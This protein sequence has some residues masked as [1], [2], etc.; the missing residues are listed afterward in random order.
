MIY[1]HF[2]F[3]S[4]IYIYVP[5]QTLFAGLK[6]LLE[7]EEDDIEEAFIQTFRVCYTDV[8]GNTLFQELKEGGDQIFV[9]Q[10]NKKVSKKFFKSIICECFGEGTGEI[11]MILRGTDGSKDKLG[12]LQ[13]SALGCAS[14]KHSS[15]PPTRP[16]RTSGAGQVKCESDKSVYQSISF[17][18]LIELIYKPQANIDL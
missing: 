3:I 8:F 17:K 2:L 5:F 1:F 10:D 18:L 6:E 7:Y 11:C 14:C 12:P 15:L 4:Y 16:S 9:N 13:S